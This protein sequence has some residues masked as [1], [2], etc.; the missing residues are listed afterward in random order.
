MAMFEDIFDLVCD[1]L[2]NGKTI[3]RIIFQKNAKNKWIYE[4]IKL[5]KKYGHKKKTG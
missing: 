4:K 1:E 3:C 5:T 2:M